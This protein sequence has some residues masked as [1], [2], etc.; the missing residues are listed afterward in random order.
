MP[1]V[2]AAYGKYEDAP[3]LDLPQWARDTLGLPLVM[4]NDARMALLGEWKAGAGQGSNDLVMLTLGTGIGT[5]AI[6]EGTL[7][8]GKHGQ[9]GVLGGHLTVRYGGRRCTCGNCGCAEAE[10]STIVLPQLASEHHDYSKSLLREATNIDYSTV[11]RLAGERDACAVAL[12]AHTVKVWSAAIV[13]LI[14]SYDP[15][16]VIIGGGIMAG[17]D[18]FFPDVVRTVL[19][20]AHT[21]WGRVDIVPAK[22][23]DAAALI[24]GE[25]LARDRLP[26]LP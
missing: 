11:L 8:R 26:D 7:V 23:G 17:E 15:E 1:R 20:H 9:A 5:A 19:A 12:R 6:V 14:H 22:L 18:A 25:I 10:A 24:G 2:L 16:R 13:N 21:P 3:H 4:E